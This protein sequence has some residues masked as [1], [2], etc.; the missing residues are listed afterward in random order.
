MHETGPE[1]QKSGLPPQNRPGTE[2]GKQNDGKEG[3]RSGANQD[4]LE[5]LFSLVSGMAI[6]ATIGYLV[7]QGFQTETPPAFEVKT[8]AVRNSGS[9]FHV[10]VT[11]RNSGDEAAQGVEISVTLK[12]PGGEES[13]GRAT[14]DWVPGRS[15]RRAVT[16][17]REDPRQGRLEARVAGYQSP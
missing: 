1:D 2:H 4:W 3:P 5:I 8:G 17:F 7:W 16:V 15:E 9:Q 13:E 10:P 12:S 6:L 11:V 14:L